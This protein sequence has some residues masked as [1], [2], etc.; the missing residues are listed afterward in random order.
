M[1][2]SGLFL[3]SDIAKLFE[4]L[5]TIRYLRVLNTPLGR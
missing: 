2:K 4:I 5:N 3:I 1:D